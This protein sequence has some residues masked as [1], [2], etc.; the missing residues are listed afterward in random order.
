MNSMIREFQKKIWSKVSKYAY[1]VSPVFASK[2]LF[3][4][5]MKK[6]L[7]LKNPKTFNEKIQWLKLYWQDPRV[8][9]CG[10]KYDLRFYVKECGLEEILNPIYGVYTDVNDINFDD[11]P[12]KFALKGTHG[13]GY[14][15][16]CKDK[17]KLDIN[18]AK[19]KAETW[20]K[21]RYAF[22]AAE[23][24]Y[25]KMEPK[26]IVEKFIDGIDG[27][28]AT[29]Y[30]VFCFNGQPHFT[31]VCEGRGEGQR[32]KYYFYN[33]DWDILPY[34]N[35]SK[36]I[37]NGNI[38]YNAEKPKCF[39]EII[40]YS[41]VLSKPFPFVRVDF[42]EVNS[43]PILGEMTFTPCG[44]I[45]SRLDPEIDLMMGELIKLPEKIIKG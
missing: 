16:I 41:E 5:A 23:I 42:Y 6:R 32:A 43:K 44:G 29:D 36:Q 8:A 3:L 31:M 17:N 9:V 39:E 35:D 21:S 26:I 28:V 22:V 33:N 13:C 24:Q 4:F 27:N 15:L 19:E 20:L 12:E 18:E 1:K 7:D 30:K 37:Y 38:K 25:D 10:D 2:L 14:N 11:L 40:K 34:N 45:D